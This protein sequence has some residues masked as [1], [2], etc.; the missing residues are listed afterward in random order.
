MTDKTPS[1]DTEDR[2]MTK[3]SPDTRRAEY[4]RRVLA[5]APPLTGEQR[6][7]LAELLKPVR[8]KPSQR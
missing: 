3:S 2:R 4:L 7:A 1:R 5:A 6:A 8:I